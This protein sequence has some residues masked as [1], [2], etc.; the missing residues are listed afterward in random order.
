MARVCQLGKGRGAGQI[1]DACLSPIGSPR[2][3][4]GASLGRISPSPCTP[5]P[6]QCRTAPPRSAGTM[7]WGGGRCRSE[8]SRGR[9]LRPQTAGQRTR[10]ARWL[11]C[12]LTQ[13]PRLPGPAELSAPS[14]NEFPS[15]PEHFNFIL[16]RSV[17]PGKAAGPHSPPAAAPAED[18]AGQRPAAPPRAQLSALGT[19]NPDQPVPSAGEAMIYSP[20]LQE[21][22]F[23]FPPLP[24]PLSLFTPSPP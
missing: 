11:G 7:G 15:R 22:L 6:L 8:R 18:P 12:R 1:R 14:L 24:G 3:L 21:L 19:H 10:R 9:G 5:P 2:S 17:A 23:L 13:F 20:G 4:P 16:A